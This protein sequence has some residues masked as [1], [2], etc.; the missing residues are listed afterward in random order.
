MST[1]L[2]KYRK[3]KALAER[4]ATEGERAAAQAALDRLEQN[5]P[6]LKRAGL[7]LPWPG[8]AVTFD[9]SRPNIVIT[10]YWA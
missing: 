2:E 8:L 10:H 6:D 9:G 1:L 5:Y 4:G 7:D 3:V